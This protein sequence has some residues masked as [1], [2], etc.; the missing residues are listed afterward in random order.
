[1]E[2]N[3]M[4]GIP[5]VV[6]YGGQWNGC[7]MIFSKFLK[8]ESDLS[9]REETSV[10]FVK[11]E[12]DGR[13]MDGWTFIGGVLRSITEL[14]YCLHMKD[15]PR[16]YTQDDIDYIRSEWPEFVR[17]YVYCAKAAMKNTVLEE[18]ATAME[19]INEVLQEPIGAVKP[20]LLQLIDL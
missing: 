10:Q 7:K 17:K 9:N 15:S 8:L 6:F 5:I 14:L 3:G 16:T 19:N 18:N 13:G 11:V 20:Y 12:I 4:V 2:V 1:M